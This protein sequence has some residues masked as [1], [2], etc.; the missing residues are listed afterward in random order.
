MTL[1][2]NSDLTLGAVGSAVTR[3]LTV[4]PRER[5]RRLINNV[6]HE[7][8][9]GEEKHAWDTLSSLIHRLPAST[10]VVSH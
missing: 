1:G 2:F 5:M 8:R 6:C 3:M 9:Q 4:P 7:H 10:S